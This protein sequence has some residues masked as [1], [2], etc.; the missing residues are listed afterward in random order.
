M[1]FDSHRTKRKT[2]RDGGSNF[3]VIQRQRGGR[4][5]K[6]VIQKRVW[7]GIKGNF[8]ES[9]PCVRAKFCTSMRRSEGVSYRLIDKSC[10]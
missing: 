10:H 3:S 9:H 5:R 6:W 1:G 2:G 7:G 4:E 8:R